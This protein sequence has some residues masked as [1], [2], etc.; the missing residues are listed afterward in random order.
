MGVHWKKSYDK[1]WQHIKNRDITNKGPS[2]QSYV[3]SSSYVWMWELDY[4]ERWPPK[5]LCFC[6]MVLEK[7]L[8]PPLDCQEIKSVNSKGNQSWI[9]TGRNYAEAEASII[10]PPEVKNWCTGKAPDAGKDWRQKEKRMTEDKMAEWHHQ[11]NGH[12]LEQAPGTGDGQGR[13]AC[14]SS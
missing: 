5:N 13:L 3:F 2:S 8:E 10:W 6:T 1:S 4:K 14:C 9:F 7:T 12:E 11:L